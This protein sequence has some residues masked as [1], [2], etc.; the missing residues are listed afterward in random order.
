M[1]HYRCKWVYIVDLINNI[2][3]PIA[4]SWSVPKIMYSG[5]KPYIHIQVMIKLNKKLFS[6]N[7]LL[8]DIQ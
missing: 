2:I 7:Y 6:H 8:F 5:E 1:R 4:K 3:F